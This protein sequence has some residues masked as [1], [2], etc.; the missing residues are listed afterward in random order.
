ML[1]NNS[2]NNNMHD[3]GIW[4]GSTA[5]CLLYSKTYQNGNQNENR[6][7][8]AAV[9][10]IFERSEFV[11]FAAQILQRFVFNKTFRS[12]VASP[13][14]FSFLS[15]VWVALLIIVSNSFIPVVLIY[16]V[17]TKFSTS[18]YVRRCTRVD[19]RNCMRDYNITAVMLWRVVVVSCCT[20]CGVSSPVAC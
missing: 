12:Y 14:Q 13:D 10:R 16:T 1:T 17:R 11:H 2:N 20:K 5:P 6:C 15:L 9:K 4:A 18:T 19:V 8:S 3:V 7:P